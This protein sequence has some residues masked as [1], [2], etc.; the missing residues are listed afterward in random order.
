MSN[1]SLPLPEFQLP[2]TGADSHA[3]LDSAK[4]WPDFEQIIAHARQVGLSRIGQ[5]FLSSAAYE[6][7]IDKMAACPELFF[8]LGIHP[9]DGHLIDQFELGR[10]R[11]ILAADQRI[12]AIGEIGLDFYWKDCP[13][14]LQTDLFIHQLRLAKQINK[15]VVIHCRDAFEET[16]A[17]LDQEDFAGRPLLWHCFGGTRQEAAMLIERDWHISIPG[18]V[19]YPANQ[20]LREAVKLIPPTRIMVETD[21]PY[22]APQPVRGKRNEPAFCA[23]TAQTVAQARNV[24]FSEFWTQCGRNAE[25]FFGLNA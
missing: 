10:M 12:K 9:T 11:Q 1:Q 23:Y 16:L 17:I 7:Y 18:P 3:H 22:L 2:C 24:S 4:L 13:H 15:P 5:I 19:T 25:L 14:A 6:Q 21:A 8:I 20:E